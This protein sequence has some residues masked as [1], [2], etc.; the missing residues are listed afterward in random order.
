MPDIQVV[1]LDLWQ[2]LI[3]DKREWGLE[4]ARLR[5]EGAVEALRDAGEPVTQEQAW[6]AYR[7]CYRA[8]KAVRQ[9]GRDVSF[10]EQV[11]IFVRDISQGLLDRISRDTFARI[12]NRYADSFFES[13]PA[14][15]QGVPGVLQ[16]IKERGYRLGMIS[17]TGM[18]PGR[19]F[20]AYLEGLNIIH[21]FDHLNFSDEVLLSKPASAMFLHTLAGMGCLAYQTVHVG[22]HLLNDIVGAQGVGMRTIWLEGFDDREVDVTPTLTIQHITDLPDALERLKG[23]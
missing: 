21:Y 13:P 18:T 17:N 3:I 12:L 19:L 4:R 2:T 5:V 15:A 7:S 11:Q 8:C 16:T 9:E 22:D 20:R 23:I 1:T 14:M 10:K 6:E